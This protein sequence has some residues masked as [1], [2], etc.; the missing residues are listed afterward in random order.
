MLSNTGDCRT[1]GK[2]KGAKS[3]WI[4]RPSVQLRN[5]TVWPGLEADS[6]GLHTCSLSLFVPWVDLV[7]ESGKHPYIKHTPMSL[8]SINCTLDSDQIISA[9]L[10]PVTTSHQVTSVSS[11]GFLCKGLTPLVRKLHLCKCDLK[12]QSILAH[13]H[14]VEAVKNLHLYT[15]KTD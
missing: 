12:P 2:H 13:S 15:R 9:P 4:R 10:S 11:S 8:T 7:E 1:Q 6:L 5:Y 14:K 3:G